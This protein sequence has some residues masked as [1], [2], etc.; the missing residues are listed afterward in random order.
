MIRMFCACMLM[1]PLI[2]C[3]VDGEPI[4]PAPKPE[5]KSGIRV[6]GEARAG[7]AITRGAV[8]PL[9]SLPSSDPNG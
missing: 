3:G 8:T 1:L 7:I 6:S 9:W 5:K 4:P 2:G